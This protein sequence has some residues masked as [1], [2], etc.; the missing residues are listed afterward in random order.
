M[1]HDPRAAAWLVW[2]E[3]SPVAVAMRQW[4][5]LYPAVEV[6]HIAGIAALVGGAVMFDLRLLGV[7]RGLPVAALAAHLLPWARVGLGMVALSGALMFT[8]HATEWA[9][10]PAFRVKLLL[11]AAAGANAWAFHRWPFRAVARWDRDL[12]A[13]APARVAALLSM[14]LWLSVIACGRLLAYL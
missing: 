11:I 13:P 3:S 5:W 6:L 1:I 10:N 4:L 12:P 9:Q 8:A 2:L 7:S 14:I